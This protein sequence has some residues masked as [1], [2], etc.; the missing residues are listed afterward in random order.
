MPLPIFYSPRHAQHAAGA[1]FKDGLPYRY[2]EVPARAEALYGAVQ[3][4]ALGPI[5]APTDHGLAP[6]HAVHPPDYVDFLQ[7]VQADTRS[8]EPVFAATMRP[9]AAPHT[10]TTRLT[11]VGHYAYG[12]DSPIWPGT[13]E[14]AYWSAQCALS[15]AE[16]LCNGERAAY[17][18]CRPPGHHTGADLYDGFCYLNNAAIAAR[19]L[20]TRV[21]GTPVAILDVDYHH[22][23]GTQ[24]IFYDD[25]TVLFCSLHANPDHDYPYF[26]GGRDELGAG[27]GLGYNRNFPLLPRTNDAQYLAAL[28]D[29]FTA[30]RAFAPRYLVVSLGLDIAEGDPL[31]S[32][33]ITTAG[34]GR[35][36]QAIA[37]LGWPT[38]IVQEGGY[39]LERLGANA[40][41]FLQA[42]A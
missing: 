31:G 36:G 14:A 20:Q 32:F 37:A 17:A 34:I 18:L 28:N 23:N 11:R 42:F 30:L 40:V 16:A 26:W 2:E 25:P 5:H 6:I 10:P 3:A 39:L 38:L 21:P 8:A 33:A 35:V 9:R 13:W 12:V 1:L 19:Y 7:N 4:A 41:A 22:G 29:A 15:A 27:A 24:M